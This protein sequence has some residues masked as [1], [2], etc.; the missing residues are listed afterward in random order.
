[1]KVFNI[2]W[3]ERRTLSSETSLMS[4]SY[5]IS[6]NSFLSDFCKIIKILAKRVHEMIIYTM[7]KI[8]FNG[9]I[10]GVFIGHGKENIISK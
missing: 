7:V 1:V 6:W 3:D 2:F 4:S 5:E 8:I 10:S 9:I